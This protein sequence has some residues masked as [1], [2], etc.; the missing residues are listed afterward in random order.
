MAPRTPLVRR[1]TVWA[2]ALSAALLALLTWSLAAPPE[3]PVPGGRITVAT[4][5]PTG[6]YAKYG[7]LLKEDLHRDLPSLDVRLRLSTGSVDNLRRLT[8]GDA[9]FA[10][11]TADAAADYVDNDRPGG[12]RLRACARLYDDYMQLV[13]PR[14]ASA[15]SIRDLKGLKV[16]VGAEGSGVQLITRRL[17]QAAGLDFTKDITPVQVGIDR[18]PDLLEKGDIDAFF[19]SGGLPTSAVLSLSRRMPVRL[20]QLGDMIGPLRT[21]GRETRFYRAAVMPADAYPAMRAT[22]VVKT[23]AV[24][25][26]LITTEDT[27]AHLTEGVTRTVIASRDRIGQVVHAAQRVDLRTAVFTDPLPLHSGARRYYVSTKP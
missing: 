21:L 3:D 17:F 8:T 22:E 6:V 15:Q 11:A 2:G 27:D 13:V 26:L 12:D 4:G 10:I 23:I 5:V 25:N 14:D 18:M 7:A 16:G 1:R 19:W 24:A 20:V 9:D